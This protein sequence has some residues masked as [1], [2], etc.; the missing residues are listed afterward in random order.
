L[1]AISVV[2][3]SLNSAKTIRRC[4]E[5]IPWASEYIIVDSGSIDGT[6]EIARSYTPHVCVLEFQGI[7]RLKNVGHDQARGPWILHLDAD[8]WLSDGLREELKSFLDSPG[9]YRAGVFNRR[10]FYRGKSLIRSIYPDRQLRLVHKEDARFVE[11][12]V[13]E[14][15][16]L[17]YPLPVHRFKADLMHDGYNDP[18]AY[19]TKLEKYARLASPTLQDKSFLSLRPYIH[20]T[21]AFLKNYIFKLGFIDGAAGWDIAVNLTRYTYLKYSYAY[22]LR[23]KARS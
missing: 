11:K 15:L 8:E 7:A 2:I 13:H 20:G 16:V 1:E 10:N 18:E 3:A 21:L 17:N 12:P 14:T 4:I 9:K 22:Q 5:S 6:D 23:K 19:R